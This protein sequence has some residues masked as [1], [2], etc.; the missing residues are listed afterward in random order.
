MKQNQWLLQQRN[1]LSYVRLH[2]ILLR[3]ILGLTR[4]RFWHSET[5]NTGSCTKHNLSEQS[6]CSFSNQH[7]DC[8]KLHKDTLETN[9]DHM[10]QHLSCLPQFIRP[11]G[12]LSISVHTDHDFSLQFRFMIPV[13]EV[14]VARFNMKVKSERK[15]NQSE[16]RF[17]S[18]ACFS[19]K[20]KS[21]LQYNS[22]T[23]LY[24]SFINSTQQLLHFYPS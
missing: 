16:R 23:A 13:N 17:T 21:P 6:L 20:V 4:N 11:K 24:C 8:D 7:Q 2:G 1:E 10:T 19:G 22:S 12:N 14:S 9:L 3:T 5:G 18:M 15:K